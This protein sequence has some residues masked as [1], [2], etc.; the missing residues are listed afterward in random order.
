MP[1]RLSLAG[2]LLAYSNP[3]AGMLPMESKRDGMPSSC[4]KR[5]KPARGFGC[6]RCPKP[7]GQ[8]PASF[9]MTARGLVHIIEDQDGES[10]PE[11]I[12]GSFEVVGESRDRRGA[13]R[14]VLLAWRD[15]DGRD[16][17]GFVRHAHLIGA[18][19]EW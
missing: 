9:K 4:A 17:R 5:R 16:Q 18:G 1:T 3:L 2:L 7:N 15:A 13:N 12:T 11:P 14:G 8:W 10:A 19:V 6:H